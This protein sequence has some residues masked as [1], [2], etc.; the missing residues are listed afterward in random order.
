VR[1][2]VLNWLDRENP[3]SGGAE[4]HLHEIFGR[5]VARGHD[6]DLLCSGWKDA[7]R[8]TTLDGIDVHRVGSRYTFQF[9][10]HR[11]YRRHLASRGY[12]VVIEDLN[13]APLYTPLWG[14]E[15]PVALVHH[16]F[17]ATGFREA[18]PA[19]ASVVWLAERPIGRVYRG[20]PF[21]AV[22]ESTAR[23]LVARGVSRSQIRV[24]YNGV[25]TEFLTPD[26]SLRSSDPRFLYV[27]R[28]KRY[29][30]IDIVV[31]GFA[32]ISDDNATLD[33]AGTG[34]FRPALEKL[35]S[36]LGLQKR[37]QFLGFVT[38]ETKVTL[39]RR[40]WASV[41]ASPK[42]GWGI[43]NIE[44][45]ACGTPVIASNSPG[46][47]DSVV[48]GETGMLV[49]HGDVTA[50][51]AAMQRLIASPSLVRTMGEAGRRFAEGFSWDK[52]ADNTI[53]HLEEVVMKGRNKWT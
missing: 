41:L 42:E 51:T 46:I 22:S 39:L 2:L 19:L 38:E 50:M 36:E 49:P 30:G 27:G 21:Q 31:R 23:D 25:N 37:V 34:D 14:I 7:P 8:R 9:F 11:Y 45:A 28:L 6:V 17:G 20:V 24:I 32:G 52:A 13:K 40:A 53:S 26:Y 15:H 48:D 18:N 35:V 3:Q 29:K 33:I 44:S 1:I 10:A 16:L 5:L 4:L 12:D 43:S 47:R